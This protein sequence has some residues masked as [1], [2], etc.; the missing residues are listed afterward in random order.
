[1]SPIILVRLYLPLV[2]FLWM[3]HIVWCKS[4]PM[5]CRYT[6]VNSHPLDHPIHIYSIYTSSYTVLSLICTC[7]PVL[8]LSQPSLPSYYQRIAWTRF[9][10][11]SIRTLNNI[12][13]ISFFHIRHW[14]RMLPPVCIKLVGNTLV[15][16]P[17]HLQIDVLLS[18]S[19]GHR[20]RVSILLQTDC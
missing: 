5:Y 14:T 15:Q 7:V 8:L 20:Y 1:M 4:N 11:G 17:V 12:W 6:V 13:C 9:S 19:R 3:A 18:I 2:M 16:Q 10:N